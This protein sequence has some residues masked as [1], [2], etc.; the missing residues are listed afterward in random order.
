M[1]SKQIQLDPNL[2]AIRNKVLLAS[3]NRKNDFIIQ[4]I[5]KTYKIHAGFLFE[6][7]K[8]LQQLCLFMSQTPN[9]IHDPSWEK[10]GH[11]LGLSV[12]VLNVSYTSR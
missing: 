7:L 1:N 5:Q 3:A 4:L 11:Q 12:A 2:E 6:D 9:K 8:T 10:F